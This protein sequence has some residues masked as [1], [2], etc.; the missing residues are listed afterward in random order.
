MQAHTHTHMRTHHT[1]TYIHTHTYTYNTCTHTHT[2]YPLTWTTVWCEL[3]GLHVDRSGTKQTSLETESVWADHLHTFYNQA[4]S[5]TNITSSQKPENCSISPE[6]WNPKDRV[7]PLDCTC[8]YNSMYRCGQTG[9][10]SDNTALGCIQQHVQVWANR[11]TV[12]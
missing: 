6:N 3:H 10:P 1:H 12:R 11:R 8:I 2:H 7:Q 4:Q 5:D 9:G